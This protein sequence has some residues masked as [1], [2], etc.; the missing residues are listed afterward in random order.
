MIKFNAKLGKSE[1]TTFKSMQQ[2]YGDNCMGRTQVFEWY[3]RFVD[4]RESLE[5]D[6]HTGRPISTRTPEIIEKIRDFIAN[7][8]NA[9]LKM[10]EEALNINRETI[11]IILHED[12][13]K[14][15]GSAKFLPHTLS[16]DQ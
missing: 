7:D 4:G 5:D 6:K 15:K 8:R 12:L 3:K 9:P 13:G 1:T 10:T 14:T 16:N 11:R 2:V